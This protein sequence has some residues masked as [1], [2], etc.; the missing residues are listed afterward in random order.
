MKFDVELRGSCSLWLGIKYAHERSSSDDELGSLKTKG[1]CLKLGFLEGGGRGVRFGEESISTIELSPRS[2][3][4]A[5]AFLSSNVAH[6]AQFL[7]LTVHCPSWS[8][9]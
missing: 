4:H 3:E 6:R 8:A 7:P 1:S 9:Q 2:A 5:K